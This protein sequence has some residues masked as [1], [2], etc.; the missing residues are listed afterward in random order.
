MIYQWVIKAVRKDGIHELRFGD[1]EGKGIE[2]MNKAQ[3][4]FKEHKK[5]EILIGKKY[6]TKL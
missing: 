5:V 1:F 6:D 3:I 4:E 2:N